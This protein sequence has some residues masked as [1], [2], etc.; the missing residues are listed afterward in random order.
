MWNVISS[1]LLLYDILHSGLRNIQRGRTFGNLAVEQLGH[2]CSFSFFK[3][4][5]AGNDSFH[6]ENNK[7]S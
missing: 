1:L 6:T 7:H 3:S 4:G 5:A 2:G